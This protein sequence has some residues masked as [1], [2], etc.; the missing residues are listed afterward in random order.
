MPSHLEGPL[1]NGKLETVNLLDSKLGL[2]EKLYWVPVRASRWSFDFIRPAF[3]TTL[4]SQDT[5]KR[6][7]RRTAWL[8]GLRGFAA[9]MVYWHHHQLW[10][11]DTMFP[12][13]NPLFENAFGY[14]DKYY[15][16]ALPFVRNFFIAGHYSVTIF[17]VV[18]GY[19]LSAKSL[20]LIQAGEFQKCG[21]AIG[22]ALFRRWLRLYIP[23]FG[24]TF[25]Y[26]TT[27]HMF[28]L[29]T[30]AAKMEPTYWKELW[31]WYTELKTYSWVF[32]DG[33]G[34]GIS[35]NFH[36]W[37]I[38][39]EFKG[40]I[41]VYTACAALARCSRNARLWCEVG[42]IVYFLYIVDGWFGAMFMGGMLLCD[43]DLLAAAGNLPKFFSYFESFKELIF[44]N[45]FIASMYLG[46]VPSRGW[47]FNV[48]KK[49]PGW[50]FLSH[51][52]SQSIFD[53]KW[54]YL[55]WAALFLIAAIPRLPWLKKFFDT[56]VNQYLGRI[57]FSLYLVHGP[58]LWVLG[59]RLYS[60]V[61]YTREAHKEHIPHWMNIFPLSKAGPLGLEPAFLAPHI[62][63]LPVTLWLAEIV[64]KI[65]DEPSVKFSNWCYQKVL[66][67]KPASPAKA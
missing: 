50:M 11:H 66:V 64:T 42:L 8:D 10:A 33:G 49:S 39:T 14:E 28:N 57:S 67:E 53:Y 17:F 63:L 31:K 51:L 6:T 2:N 13:Q 18:S 47:D 52:K 54:F 26:M 22:S 48:L 7:V 3:V 59:E 65:F 27:W 23:V 62:I 25:V 55:F 44:L 19:V 36:A 30:M 34:F 58:V 24:T 37:S 46:G 20:S 41:I 38:P 16:A 60:A 12:T 32:R 35:Y 1:D 43:L 4:I 15:F 29:W 9:L 40:S 5:K 21:D 45:L 56:R 61:G